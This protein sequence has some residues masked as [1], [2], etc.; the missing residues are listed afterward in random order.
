[1]DLYQLS[2]SSNQVLFIFLSVS[3]RVVALISTKA[4][5]TF[6][7]NLSHTFFPLMKSV[8]R[9]ILVYS[10]ENLVLNIHIFRLILVYSFENL[11]LNIHIPLKKIEQSVE[12]DGLCPRQNMTY[13]IGQLCYEKGSIICCKGS[14]Q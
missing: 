8:Y 11:V 7:G 6:N 3:K 9:L 12:T 5:V 4:S 2:V 1:V 14:L 13:G 10:F